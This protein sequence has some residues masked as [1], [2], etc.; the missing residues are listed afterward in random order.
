MEEEKKEYTDSMVEML[1]DG[2]IERLPR[3][4]SM[5]SSERFCEQE[6]DLIPRHRQWGDLQAQLFKSDDDFEP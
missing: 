3:E 1:L 4:S 5:D 2:S 6:G